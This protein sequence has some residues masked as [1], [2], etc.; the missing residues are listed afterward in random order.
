M[1]HRRLGDIAHWLMKSELDVY[2]WSSLVSDGFTHWDGVRNYQARNLMRDQMTLGDLILFYH[3]NC[4][5][6]HVAGVARVRREA[7]PDHT[8]WDPTSKYHDPKSTPEA[9]AGSWWTSSPCSGSQRSWRCRNSELTLDWRGCL[10]SPGSNDFPCNPWRTPISI[11]SVDWVVWILRR[12][13]DVWDHD[14]CGS[15]CGGH[16]ICDT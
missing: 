9:P 15:T 10:C 12:S 11:T 2:P 14:P 5:P 16:P 6:P 1:T 8:S 13:M 7:Y 3:S 4:K